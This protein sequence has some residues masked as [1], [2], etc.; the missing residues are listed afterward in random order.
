[1]KEHRF[2]VNQLV[3]LTLRLK[4]RQKL[5]QEKTGCS[6]KE[7]RETRIEKGEEGEGKWKVREIKMRIESIFLLF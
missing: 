7:E 6:H 2:T 4:E 1:M 5:E 3:S